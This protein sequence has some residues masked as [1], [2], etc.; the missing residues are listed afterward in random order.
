MKRYISLAGALLLGT[1][2][3]S[4]KKVAVT[5]K[6]VAAARHAD[7]AQVQHAHHAVKVIY[8]NKV[9]ETSVTTLADEVTSHNTNDRAAVTSCTSVDGALTSNKTITSVNDVRATTSVTKDGDVTSHTSHSTTEAASRVDSVTTLDGEMSS[10]K[11]IT[12][13]DDVKSWWDDRKNARVASWW[14]DKKNARVTSWWDD[15]KNARVASWWDDKKN[16]RVASWWDAKNQRVASWWDTKAQKKVQK[17]A[18]VASW[19][20]TK[21]A[22][23][24]IKVK[25]H[26]IGD[27]GENFGQQPGAGFWCYDESAGYN[28]GCAQL[29]TKAYHCCMA[30]DGCPTGQNLKIW[31]LDHHN[32]DDD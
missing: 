30:F 20:D 9:A 22:V 5:H 27:C 2:V 24:A 10:N 12:S 7:V 1:V 16:A 25:Q 31:H 14:D 17:K 23:K 4:T 32:Q 11:T 15:K 29:T 3:A 26:I 13:V 6:S 18:R 28:T 21:K 19:W 8:K